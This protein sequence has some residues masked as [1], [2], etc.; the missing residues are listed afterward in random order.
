MRAL[1]VG[2]AQAAAAAAG[3]ADVLTVGQ[4][5]GQHFAGFPILHDG[6]QGHF[7]QDAL[8]IAA[9]AHAALSLATALGGELTLL[10][11]GV[12]G[13]QGPVGPEGDRAALAAVA[14]IG[15]ALG[16]E[17][18]A[19]FAAIPAVVLF[20]VASKR[21]DDLLAGVEAASGANFTRR[22]LMAPAPP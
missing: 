22:K 3:D 6:A 21:Q 15:T 1:E 14:A 8:A 12:E 7:E 19:L 5:F 9:M 11:V 20:N 13:V 2:V 4:E 16:G 10:A 17:L 18:L